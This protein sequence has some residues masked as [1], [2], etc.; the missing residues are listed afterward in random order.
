MEDLS[1][2]PL[3]EPKNTKFKVYRMFNY[4]TISTLYALVNIHKLCPAIVASSMADEYKVTLVELGIF[5]AMYFYPYAIMQPIS[6]VLAD[7][8]DSSMVL[9]LTGLLAAIGSTL[10]GLSKSLTVGIIGRLMVGIGTG[11]TYVCCLRIISNWFK[12]D[13]MPI[14][15]GILMAASCLGGIIAGTP[16]SLFCKKFG[17]RIA[18]YTLGGSGSFISLLI[19]FFT[20]GSPE[21]QGFEPVNIHP[22]A[23]QATFGEK[24]KQLGTS[25]CQVLGYKYFWVIVLFNITNVCPYLNV[26]G[27]WGGPFLRD[28][29]GFQ[30][31]E[32]GNILMFISI[33]LFFGSVLLPPCAQWIK[34]KK[35]VLIISS[36]FVT[37]SMLSLYVHGDKANKIL[38]SSYYFLLGAFTLGV[39]NLNYPLLASYYNPN[40]SG[41]A[42]GIAN[43]FLFMMIAVYQQITGVILPKFG[44][45]PTPTGTYKYTWEGYKY[46]LWL[47]SAVSTALSI[48]VG[49]IV[50]EP[51]ANPC[52]LKKKPLESGESPLL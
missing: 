52:G 11:P 9:G 14:L 2:A 33:G 3:I 1:S 36:F 25:I 24:M 44:K 10:C 39:A 32:Q 45:T 20:R 16:L 15:L 47:F 31:T 27:Y 28:V 37:G 8:F 22:P 30:G 18:F 7:M 51:D 17:W 21:K 5:S 35:I 4:I 19:I 48:F 26:G 13:K 46:G 34:S 6:G 42:V 43:F 50:Y 12:A 38:L 49:F 29:R 41:S 40:I 23:Q